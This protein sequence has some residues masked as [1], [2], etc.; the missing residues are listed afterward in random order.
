MTEDWISLREM[1]RRTGRTH[2]AVQKAIK[3]GRI[4]ELCVRRAADGSVEAI[5][6]YGAKAA[7]ERNTDQDQAL[8]TLAMSSAASSDSGAAGFDP[9]APPEGAGEQLSLEPNDET[10]REGAP[11]AA[12]SGAAPKAGRA[13][14][15]ETKNQREEVSLELDRLKLAKEAGALIA[16]DEQRKASFQ[17]WRSARDQLRTIPERTADLLAAESDP[18]NVRTLLLREIDQVL[19]GLSDFARIEAAGGAGERSTA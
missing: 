17:I 19:N 15:I 6:Y 11:G 1:G 16:R 13:A 10:K 9:A 3:D 18:A 5:E 14:Y 2:G 8:R 12:A 4:P 7:W